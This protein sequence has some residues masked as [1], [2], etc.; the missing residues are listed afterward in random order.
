MAS[1]TN[2]V[3]E[4]SPAKLEVNGLVNDAMETLKEYE[5]YN[6]KKLIILSQN[7]Q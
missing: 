5:E 6:Q 3:K 1:K 7:V 2:E 4:L